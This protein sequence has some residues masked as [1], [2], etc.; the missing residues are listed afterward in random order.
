[1]VC[2]QN[3]RRYTLIGGKK[4]KKTFFVFTI[5]IS[6]IFCGCNNM[7]NDDQNKNFSTDNESNKPYFSN[8]SQKIYNIDNEVIG[9]LEHYGM[10]MQTEDSIIYTKIPNG[11]T[12]TITSM[13][14]Y[15]YVISTKEEIKLGTIEN[16]VQLGMEM[17]YIDNHLYFFVATGNIYDINHR[18]LNLV[19]IDL[20][21]NTLSEIFSEKGGWPY[22]S[23]T[24]VGDK[25]L[26]TKVLVNGCNL[27][28]YNTKT[29]ET[30]ILKH[31]DFDDDANI[32]ETVRQISADENSISLLILSMQTEQNVDLRVDT[33]DWNMHLIN[34]AD[35]SD[36]SSDKN[37]LRQGVEYFDVTNNYVYY[38]NFSL[39]RFL[40]KIENE[41]VRQI[42]E[43]NE[44]LH[45]IVNETDKN[46]DTNLFYEMYGE[47]NYLYLFNSKDGSI[48]RARFCADDDRYNIN[49]VSRD[50][51]DKLLLLMGYRDPDT[52][53]RLESKL[54]Y[55]DLSDLDFT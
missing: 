15:R 38:Q 2:L 18:T 30:E 6:I 51:N 11:A 4:L 5:I 31:F 20:I 28:I 43:T 22:N 37:D 33:Y 8:I 49:N 7:T 48:K 26:M 17:A 24:A 46:K 13:D 39:K 35:M 10:F 19:D 29:K 12:N 42:A 54:Y 44:G 41:S 3:L 16:W 47:N 36:I 53:E 40:G 25:I 21:N 1:M 50:R 55:I 32:G 27:E 34:S 52:G 45:S 9:E 23:M 14:Y